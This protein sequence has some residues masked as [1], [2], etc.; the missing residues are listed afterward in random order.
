[1]RVVS[2]YTAIGGAAAL[3][4]AVDDFY[5]RVLAD[6]ELAGYFIGADVER[7]KA[8]QRMFIAA[9]I[10]G[11]TGYRGRPMRDAHAG[12]H[13]RDADFDRVVGHLA[14]T[15]CEL[16]VGGP[17]IEAIAELLVPLR[18]QIVETPMPAVSTAPR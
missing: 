10:G 2:I 15:L 17:T 6:R 12:L 3:S 7:I 8:H 11:P 18:E 4:A 14:A 9:A 5:R 13:I 1:V 16:G